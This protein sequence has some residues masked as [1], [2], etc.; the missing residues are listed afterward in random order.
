[1]IRLSDVLADQSKF[2][3]DKMK[4]KC[5]KIVALTKLRQYK[6]A[7]DDIDAI[8]PFLDKKNSYE[9][10]PEFYGGLRGTRYNGH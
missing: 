2:P 5:C 3:H 4:M 9:G 6:Q 10:Y 8:G 1:V 7:S